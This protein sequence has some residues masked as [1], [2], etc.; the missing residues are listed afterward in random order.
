MGSNTTDKGL[1]PFVVASYFTKDNCKKNSHLLYIFGD[2]EGR[3]GNGGQAQIRSEVN[4]IGI[5]TKRS[6]SKFWDDSELE[7]SKNVID[8]DIK[9]VKEYYT[10]LGVKALCFP[11]SGLGTGLSE[12][13]LR[14]PKTF[15]Y[16]TERLLEEFGY[17]N[18][19][20]LKTD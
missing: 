13:H 8:D 16:L 5:A 17:N 7:W 12:L 18:F 1:I 9:R 14:A 11:K 10:E 6:I 3:V 4:A 2:N 15:I 19:M 20:G